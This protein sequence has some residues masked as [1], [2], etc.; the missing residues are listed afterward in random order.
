[1]KP[2]PDLS[3]H[4]E[5]HHG[6]SHPDWPAIWNL[7]HETFAEEELHPAW[8]QAATVWIRRLADQ[9]GAGY[10]V[11][12]SRN[13]ILLSAKSQ[14]DAANFLH[15]CESSLEEILECLEGA[16][17][18]AGYGRHVIFIFASDDDYYRYVAPLYPDGESPMSG[19]MCISR[20]Y[21]HIV[22]PPSEP[23][24]H[25]T[26]MVHEL[27][28]VCLAHLPLP[29]WLNEALAMRMEQLVCGTAT[30][31]LD[32]EVHRRHQAHWN[33]ET[34]QQF[35]SGRSWTIPGDSFELSYNLAE[36]LWRKIE[37]ELS[38]P[39][40]VVIGFIAAADWRDAGNSAFREIYDLGLADL[41]EDFLGEGDWSPRPETWEPPPASSG[42]GV[43]T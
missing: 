33:C 9:L 41:V 15:L 36:V 29:A 18:D 2:L 31:V 43:S 1:M 10:R 7:I 24:G 39:R 34:I 30:F 42:D 26:S 21:S 32:G 38:A 13:F 16:A 25:H 20:G 4:F 8:D 12:G 23:A 3:D 22:M 17:S 28:H 27:T 5:D 37:G 19:G 6:L 40:E 11:D 35:W 14:R